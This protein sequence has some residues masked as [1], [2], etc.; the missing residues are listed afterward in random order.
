MPKFHV[1]PDLTR[2]CSGDADRPVCRGPGWP[3]SDPRLSRAV[4]CRADRRV[5][6][7]TRPPRFRHVLDPASLNCFA[8]RRCVANARCCRVE[9]VLGWAGSS[10]S[11][12][13]SHSG[14]GGG[15]AHVSCY[16]SG[17]LEA[18]VGHC[19]HP[20]AAGEPRRP[21]FPLGTALGGSGDL[22]GCPGAP[23]R[24]QTPF[25]VRLREPAHCRQTPR[26]SGQ[27]WR[28]SRSVVH[29]RRGV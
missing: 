29:D 8:P 6:A 16:G 17:E 26:V 12:A 1:A 22:G 21:W 7:R 11:L 3:V 2:Q 24:P 19:Q 15:L 9:G 5:G 23:A 10:V 28:A 27:G 13:R 14:L 18:A 4:P 25:P 20:R